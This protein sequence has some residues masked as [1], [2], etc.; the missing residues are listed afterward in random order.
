MPWHAFIPPAALALVAV[1][2]W[3]QHHRRRPDRRR[4]DGGFQ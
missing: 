2:A 3:L 1:A 4:H